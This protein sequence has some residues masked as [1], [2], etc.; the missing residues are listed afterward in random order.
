MAIERIVT[1]EELA[2]L[3]LPSVADRVEIPVSWEQLFRLKEHYASR[4]R[5]AVVVFDGAE[6]LLVRLPLCE[7]MYYVQASEVRK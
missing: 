7:I 2:R 4:R 1:Q 3:G 5:A 6:Q